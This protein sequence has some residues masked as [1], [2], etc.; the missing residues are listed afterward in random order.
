MKFFIYLLSIAVVI[1]L[2]ANCKQTPKQEAN[3]EQSASYTEGLG[4]IQSNCISCHSPKGSLP[5]EVGP[6]LQNLR[7]HYLAAEKTESAFINGM[8]RFLL[9]PEASQSRMP[10]AVKQF[11]LMPNLGYTKEQYDAVAYYLFHSNMEDPDW[12]DNQYAKEIKTLLATSQE[13][14]VDYLNKGREIALSAKSILGKN[15]LTAINTKGVSDALL[16][17]NE[18]AI[19]LTDSMAV[20]LGA[21]L[22]RVSDKNRNPANAAEAEELAYILEAK[23]AIQSQGTAN[24]KIL[25]K[26]NKVVGF[27]PIMTNDMCLKCHGATAKDMDTKTLDNIRRLY[28]EDKA[29]G[30]A[31][32]ELRGIWVVEMQKQ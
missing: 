1:H 10:E 21:G 19:P 17:C 30:Y 9:K 7:Q 29:T 27:Y 28:P 26:G 8:S 3:P 22:K 20:A 13:G 16:F 23:A 18:R 32:N 12:Y 6:S 14:P 25:D 2:L 11:G 24:P 31:V 4:I 15:L 5:G